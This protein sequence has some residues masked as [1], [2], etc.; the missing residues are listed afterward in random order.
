MAVV[1]I[2]MYA[3]I[4]EDCAVLVDWRALGAFAILARVRVRGLHGVVLITS[5]VSADA[6]L[7]AAASSPGSPNP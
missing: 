3:F 7:L 6:V 4:Q 1:V 2:V 5:I